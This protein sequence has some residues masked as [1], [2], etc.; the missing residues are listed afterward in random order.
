MTVYD[1]KDLDSIYCP[2]CNAQMELVAYSL[3]R[4]FCPKCRDAGYAV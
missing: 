1:L 3:T 4:M 2:K